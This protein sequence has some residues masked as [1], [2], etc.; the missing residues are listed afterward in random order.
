MGILKHYVRNRACPEGSIIEGYVT[1]EVIEFCLDYMERL[2]LVGV[3]RSVHE[4]KLTSVGT[5]GRAKFRP[6][7]T[8]YNHAHFSVMNHMEEITPYMKEHIAILKAIHPS[9]RSINKLHISQFNTWFTNRLCDEQAV[10]PR[11][12]TLAR[13]PTW[14]VR[15]FQMYKINYEGKR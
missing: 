11:V 14:E 12:S 8:E 15:K 7:S 9:R 1:E 3:P 4:G 6:T 5:S 2:E 13:G 10:D